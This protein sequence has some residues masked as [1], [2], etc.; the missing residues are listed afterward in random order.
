MDGWMDENVCTYLSLLLAGTLTGLTVGSDVVISSK[1][2]ADLANPTLI[3]SFYR[4]N[5]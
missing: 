5:V 3:L 2:Q 4:N 1:M